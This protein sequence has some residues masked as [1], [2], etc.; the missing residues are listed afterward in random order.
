M[1]NSKI[2]LILNGM[3]NKSGLHCL[4]F[5]VRRNTSFFN[6]LKSSQIFW[7]LFSPSTWRVTILWFLSNQWNFQPLLFSFCLY[8]PKPIHSLAYLT[9]DHNVSQFHIYWTI[10]VKTGFCNLIFWSKVLIW[11]TSCLCINFYPSIYFRF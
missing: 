8:K 7:S 11:I 2:F 3:S 4:G 1:S 6:S 5:D 10:W 9:C